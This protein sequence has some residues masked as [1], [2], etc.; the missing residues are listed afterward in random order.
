MD[1][2]IHVRRINR[3]TQV[4]KSRLLTIDRDKK[5]HAMAT[6]IN[7]KDLVDKAIEK[8]TLLVMRSSEATRMMKKR[9]SK[10]VTF[11]IG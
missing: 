1:A 9:D 4:D 8:P 2:D 6:K 3:V 11:G 10:I 5:R 7:K